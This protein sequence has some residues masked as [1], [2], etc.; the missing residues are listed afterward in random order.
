M[1]LLHREFSLCAFTAG[2][3][4]H[5][6]CRLWKQKIIS[7]IR[8]GKNAFY[9]TWDKKICSS[10]IIL[11]VVNGNMKGTMSGKNDR[12]FC[13]ISMF[14]FQEENSE[15]WVMDLDINQLNYYIYKD[16]FFSTF[17]FHCIDCWLKNKVREVCDFPAYLC[18]VFLCVCLM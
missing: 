2:W 7:A 17:I 18:F 10:Y 9:Y 11:E 16:S 15:T 3:Y 1:M 12:K 14:V 13:F 8:R 5:W 6:H 4:F